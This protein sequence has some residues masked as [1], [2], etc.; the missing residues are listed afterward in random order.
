[1][2]ERTNTVARLII[3]LKSFRLWWTDKI[4]PALKETSQMQVYITT[5]H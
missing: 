5:H 4:Y 3:Y 2:N 1:M